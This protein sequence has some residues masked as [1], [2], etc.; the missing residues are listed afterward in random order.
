MLNI[1][2][3]A[4]QLGRFPAVVPPHLDNAYRNASVD[5]AT[6][7]A[8]GALAGILLAILFG[9]LLKAANARTGT[10]SP[11]HSVASDGRL[12]PTQRG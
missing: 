9:H 5:V 8:L 12:A 11:H 7:F 2:A 3:F 1:S 10:D 4:E 6:P